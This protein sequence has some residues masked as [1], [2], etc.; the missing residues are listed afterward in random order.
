MRRSPKSRRGTEDGRIL[1]VQGGHD[2]LEL[3]AR[4]NADGV[5][6]LSAVTISAF[7]IVRVPRAWDS[8]ERCA[9]EADLHRE[10][11]RLARTFRTAIDNWTQ[12]IAALVTWIRYSPA[13]P[14]A[15]PAGPSFDDQSEDDDGGGPD[16]L[17]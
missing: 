12:T 14:G 13:P 3:H 7:R 9:A 11:D 6:S 1:A 15:K 4:C 8:P 17:H 16:N 5:V 2:A 10:L